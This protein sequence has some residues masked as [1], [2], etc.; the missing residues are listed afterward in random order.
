MRNLTR[1]DSI[2]PLQSRPRFPGFRWAGSCRSALE[3]GGDF[4]DVMALS[5]TSLLIAIADVMGK[6]LTAAVFANSL[7]TYLRALA[8]PEVNPA[9]LLFELNKLMFDELS[10]AELFITVQLV[11]ADLFQR[12]LNIASAGHCPSLVC[13]HNGRLWSVSP[14]GLPLGIELNAVFHNQTTVLPPFGSVLLYTDGVTEARDPQ[15]R[16]FGQERLESWLCGGVQQAQSATQLKANLL[17]ELSAFRGAA[18]LIDDQT[19]V[20][21]CDETPRSLDLSSSDEDWSFS[22]VPYLSRV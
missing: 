10:S 19:F 21:L 15:G 6:G 12:Q 2:L 5:E 22:Q 18:E 4:Y 3:V 13:G 9:E 7:R 20:L 1:L 14:N 8:K 16:F 11:V 17:Y